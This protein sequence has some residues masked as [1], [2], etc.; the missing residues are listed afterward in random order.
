MQNAIWYALILLIHAAGPTGY[1]EWNADVFISS[2]P[3]YRLEIRGDF[4]SAAVYREGELIGEIESSSRYRQSYTAFPRMA[5]ADESATMDVPEAGSPL[6]VPDQ[7]VDSAPDMETADLPETRNE[8]AFGSGAPAGVAENAE[9]RFAGGSDIRPI[10][11]DLTPVLDGVRLPGS[12]SSLEIE[13]TGYEDLFSI[14]AAGASGQSDG[15]SAA[16]GWILR[17]DTR[18]IT[19]A[20]P[21]LGLLVI[22]YL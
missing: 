7:T 16:G 18:Q 11:F 6:N 14:S 19:A 8:A 15:A 9:L 3:S 10:A 4:R 20:N 5:L 17:R 12:G 13:T 22:L 2:V 1:G 21:S